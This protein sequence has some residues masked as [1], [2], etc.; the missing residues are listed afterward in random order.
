MV[1][2]LRPGQSAATGVAGSLM[3]AANRMI[4]VDGIPIGVSALAVGA[5]ELLEICNS[6]LAA[7][8]AMKTRPFPVSAGWR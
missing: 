8:R 1:L 4:G 2:K 5:E 6:Y 3:D 7:A